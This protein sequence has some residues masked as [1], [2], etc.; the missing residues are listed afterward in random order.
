MK[1]SFCKVLISFT[2]SLLIN[3]GHAKSESIK[4]KADPIN[5]ATWH[6]SSGIQPT[7][8]GSLTYNRL[9]T[10]YVTVIVSN[11]AKPIL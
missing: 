5:D 1:C 3:E 9:G 6:Y 10:A 11:H 7:V 8:D 2:C 4:I